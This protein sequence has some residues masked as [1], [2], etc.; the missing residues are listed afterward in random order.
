MKP[1]RSLQGRLLVLV[2][3]VVATVWLIA[4]ALTWR[5]ARREIDQLLDSHLAQAAA[6]LVMQQAQ[7]ADD[8]ETLDAPILHPYAPKVVFQVFHEGRLGMHSANAPA[9]PMVPPQERRVSGFWTVEID[10]KAWRV[11]ATPSAQHDVEVYVGERID[12]RTSILMAVMRSAFWPMAGAL[13]VLALVTWWAVRRGAAPLRD[14]GRLLARRDPRALDA[15]Q[16]NRAPQEMQPMLDALNRLFDRIRAVLDAERRFTADAAHELRTP[17][18][19]IKAQA[20]VAMAEDDAG[21]R[22]H[23]LSGVLEGCDR[24]VHLVDQLLL[25]S[26]LEAG[27]PTDDNA[28]SAAIDLG[29]VAKQ[30]VADIAPQSIGRLQQLEFEAPGHCVVIGNEVLLA[31][32][33]R[34]LVDNAV[35]YSPTRARISV[36]VRHRD[37]HVTLAVEDSGPGLPEDDL[38]RLGERFFRGSG[39]G[40][41]GS[42]LGWSIVRRIAGAHGAAIHVGRSR[43]LGGLRVEIS[44]ID[45]SQKEPEAD[46]SAVTRIAS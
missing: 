16:M 22:R 39:S 33:I 11:F 37:S 5:D 35:R 24:M 20:Q 10:G 38:R 14:L 15:V 21:L 41:S 3:G 18:A 1:P 29:A 17:I 2:T 46:S 43:A 27:T 19:A 12:S 7:A 8:D 4:S 13:P 23:A 44:W 31:S 9:Q 36:S 34:N 32:L 30:V 45:V 42:G 6:L 25:L 40:Q 28:D 26:R